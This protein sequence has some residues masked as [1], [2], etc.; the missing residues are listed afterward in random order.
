MLIDDVTGIR[1][2]FNIVV[3]L[4]YYLFLSVKE[5]DNLTA[6][7]LQLYSTHLIQ[8][9]NRKWLQF[10][11]FKPQIKLLSISMGKFDT[12]AEKYISKGVRPDNIE[13]AISAVKDGTRREHIIDSLT[14]D[15]RGMTIFDSMHLLDEL[16]EANGGEFK[17]ENRGGYLYGTLFLLM[18]LS[19]T[20]YICYV[21]LFGGVIVRPIL[22]GLGAITG[23][24]T[25]ASFCI[26]S[27]RGKYR[28]EDEPFK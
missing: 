18:G 5:K 10:F 24:F 20:F 1:S 6:T 23:T 17:K 26:K 22:V 25:G 11:N 2:T 13:Y 12:V 8:N 7:I 4:F 15:Y 27:I 3:N 19:C 21:L 28:D 14:A 16:Y 9:C